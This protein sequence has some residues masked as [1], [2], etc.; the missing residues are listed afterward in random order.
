MIIH[1]PGRQ[2]YQLLFEVVPVRFRSI[3]NSFSGQRPEICSKGKRKIT[4]TFVS[5][6]GREAGT[7]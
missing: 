4:R 1:V 6:A 5:A 2:L 3:S 7:Y